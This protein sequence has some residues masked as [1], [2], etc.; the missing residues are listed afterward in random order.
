MISAN[1]D[2]KTLNSDLSISENSSNPLSRLFQPATIVSIKHT[3]NSDQPILLDGDDDSNSNR[4]QNEPITGGNPK[5][6]S[7]P[8]LNKSTMENEMPERR[9]DS[10]IKKILSN[11]PLEKQ[12]YVEINQKVQNSTVSASKVH[13]STDLNGLERTNS[14]GGRESTRSRGS[15]TMRMLM[16]ANGIYADGKAQPMTATEITNEQ[17]N[18]RAASPHDRSQ[19]LE[20]L[21]RGELVRA[22]PALPKSDGNNINKHRYV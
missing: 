3:D 11:Q 4:E 2:N 13:S 18:K 1:N 8:D 15:I 21:I 17:S 14:A 10:S 22:C 20:Y 7:N 19:S 5:T 16:G 6:R 9:R 12:E